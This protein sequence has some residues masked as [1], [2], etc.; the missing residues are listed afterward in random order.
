MNE[1]PHRQYTKKLNSKLFHLISEKAEIESRMIRLLTRRCGT[2]LAKQFVNTI[3]F[4]Y[5]SE[6]QLTSLLIKLEQQQELCRDPQ[7]ADLEWDELAK[8]YYKLE[9]ITR[10]RK[11]AEQRIKELEAELAR[12]ENQPV[13]FTP[14]IPEKPFADIGLFG[15]VSDRPI[16]LEEKIMRI[17]TEDSQDIVSS[18]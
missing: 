2:E 10:R 1:K 13:E 7:K 18:V 5:K 4:K 8:P 9:E 12:Y 17:D 3:D 14:M 6:Q 11:I 16:S 15:Q